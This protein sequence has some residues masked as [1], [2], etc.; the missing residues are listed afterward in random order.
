MRQHHFPE[1]NWERTLSST[2]NGVVEETF[3]H[4][5][6]PLKIWTGYDRANN[7]AFRVFFNDEQMCSSMMYV[8]NRDHFVQDFVFNALFITFMSTNKAKPY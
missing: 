1:P 7:M 3:K 4:K 5:Q 6:F 8:V 2:A